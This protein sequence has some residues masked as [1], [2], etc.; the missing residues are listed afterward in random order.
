MTPPLKETT[1][2]ILARLEE[3]LK[4]LTESNNKE[5]QDI[6]NGIDKLCNHVNEEVEKL[7]GKIQKGEERLNGLEKKDIATESKY[8]GRMELYK[9]LSGL[10]GITLSV[11]ALLKALGLF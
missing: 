9:W 11:I 8:K 7:A 3:R 5:H 1:T 4:G 10:M 2:T 6:L